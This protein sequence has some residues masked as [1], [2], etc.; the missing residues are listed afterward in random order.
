VELVPKLLSED[1]LLIDFLKSTR[2]KA[3]SPVPFYDERFKGCI[4]IF[5][6]IGSS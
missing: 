4:L 6:I 3:V 2:K 5:H 1:P